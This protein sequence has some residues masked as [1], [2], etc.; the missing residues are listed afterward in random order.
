MTRSTRAVLLALTISLA[1]GA[2]QTSEIDFYSPEKAAALGKA[3]AAELERNFT[4]LQ[5]SVVAEYVNEIGQRLAANSTL[6]SPLTI[7]LVDTTEIVAVG[8]PGGCVILSSGLIGV[9][10]TESELAGVMAHQIAHIAA[11]HGTRQAAKGQVANLASIPLIFM[12][13][14]SGICSRLRPRILL[15][16]AFLQIARGQE[17]EADLLGFEYLYKAGYDPTGLVTMFQKLQPKSQPGARPKV[18]PRFDEVKQ[19]LSA[20]PAQKPPS[21][22]K[23]EWDR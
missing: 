4:P 5:D 8:L 19:R 6:S 11:R 21:L 16:V 18:N 14:W 13:G 12:G 10:G 7:K 15:P 3:L 22:R 2:A 17:R 20:R 9:A 1:F 23:T